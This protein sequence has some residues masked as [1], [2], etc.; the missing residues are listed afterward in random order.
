MPMNQKI[1]FYTL[2]ILLSL[3]RG[4]H[5]Q[6]IMDG[7][8]EDWENA[9]YIDDKGDNVAFDI[10]K[11]WITND[12]NYLY[13]R[14]D[15]DLIFDLQEDN[16][17]RL[18][19]DIDNNS[20]TGIPI[21]G[22][23]A[24]IIYNFRQRSGQL[25]T[26][27]SVMAINHSV[28]GI[29]A[30]P[31]FTS[32]S[33]EIAILR[34]FRFN[35]NQYNMSGSI[36]IYVEN[37][38]VLK[39]KIPNGTGG[40]IYNMDNTIQSKL[41]PYQLDKPTTNAI[42]ILSYNVENDGLFDNVKGPLQ[43][44]IIQAVNP[45]IIAFQEIYFRPSSSVAQVM[46]TIL[47]LDH[48]DGWYHAKVNPDIVTVSKYPIVAFNAVDGNGVFL[49]D[50]PGEPVLV[51]YNAHLPCCNNNEGRRREIDKILATLRDRENHPT[52]SFSIPEGSPVIIAGDLNLVGD[53]NQYLALREGK[54]S[55]PTEH[56]TDFLPDWGKGSLN[57]ASP[58]VTNRPATITWYDP[59][60]SYMAG[61]LDYFLYTSSVAQVTNSYSLSTESMTN[62]EMNYFGFDDPSLTTKAS[63][64]LPLIA[65]FIFSP[66]G[67]TTS[68]KKKYRSEILIVPNPAENR[69]FISGLQRQ[70][71]IKIFNGNGQL[72]LSKHNVDPIDEINISGFNPG[73]YLL[74]INESIPHCQWFIKH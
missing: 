21:N 73:K 49:I 36:S 1:C 55:N 9:F 14:I 4:I 12:E 27:Q 54:I 66:N 8:F 74:C 59:A 11:L 20:N 26:G 47:P 58:I 68:L 61:K 63:D 22:I 48:P 35:N 57:D 46:N 71:G 70:T 23:G 17:L 50:I 37:D 62:E 39:D 51:L 34:S 52:I 30:M 15:T 29:F 18:A 6:I 19:I 7:L 41:T 65:D 28:P 16:N 60:S 31:T 56:G 33:F 25:H 10:E 38:I 43:R 24:E 44:K 72:L 2:I 32:N 53:R 69:I 5:A 67:N 40:V 13:L 42:R 3:S 64:H 45:D